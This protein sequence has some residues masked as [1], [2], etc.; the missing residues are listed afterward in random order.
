MKK[1]EKNQIPFEE[2]WF[3]T[4]RRDLML[5]NPYPSN[6]YTNKGNYVLPNHTPS[7]S[8]N[9]FNTNKVLTPNGLNFER[10]L[11]KRGRHSK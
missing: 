1:E 9:P 6:L 5:S 4:K 8:S 7:F 11:G 2:I 10:G 3:L